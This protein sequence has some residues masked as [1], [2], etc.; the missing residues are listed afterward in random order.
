VNY[1]PLPQ[2]FDSNE[3]FVILSIVVSFSLLFL[4]P[5]RFP[6][7][8]SI[9][10]LSFSIFIARSVDEILA[11]PKVNFYDVIDSGKYELFDVISYAMYAPS[12]YFFIYFFDKFKFK[13]FYLFFYIV[14][15]SLIGWGFE[16]VCEK[17]GVFTYIQWQLKYSLAVYLVVQPLTLL[18]YQLISQSHQ[19]SVRINKS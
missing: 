8:I 10:I 5:R 13:G 3:W 2:Q 14:S 1:L 19:K 4:L 9:L 12:A 15:F 18:F 17:F 6:L 16:W 7:S 11:G